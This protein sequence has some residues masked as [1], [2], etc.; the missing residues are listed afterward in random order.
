MAINNGEH[1]S[2]RRGLNRVATRFQKDEIMLTGQKQHL[3][4]PLL[5]VFMAVFITFFI[6]IWRV[7]GNQP[8]RQIR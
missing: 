2:K 6:H 8:T 7:T 1:K 5:S 3:I 4:F